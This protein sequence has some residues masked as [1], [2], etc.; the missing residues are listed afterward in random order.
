MLKEFNGA[1]PDQRA[2]LA[3]MTRM[4][5]AMAS[6]VMVVRETIGTAGE[7]A[8]LTLEAKGRDGKKL[9]GTAFLAN[10]DGR[11]KMAALEGWP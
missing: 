11:W 5:N 7:L 1:P 9:T 3:A 10:E 4:M 8:T 6:N 2:D